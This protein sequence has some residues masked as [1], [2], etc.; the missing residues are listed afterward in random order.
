MFVPVAGGVANGVATH[1]VDDDPMGE[2]VLND[3][4]LSPPDLAVDTDLTLPDLAL[5]TD[6][7]NADLPLSD[8]NT[9][10]LADVAELEEEKDTSEVRAE[11]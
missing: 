5:A 2:L 10:D 11:H 9:A 3:V 4:D 7:P 6:L 1:A 8:I